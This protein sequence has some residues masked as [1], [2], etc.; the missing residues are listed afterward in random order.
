MYLTVTICTRNRAASLGRT[1]ASIER[2]KR[3]ACDWELLV[4]DNGSNDNTSE[5]LSAFQARLPI[6]TQTQPVPG[7]SRARNAAIAAAAGHYLISTDDDVL[8]DPNWL[9]AFTDS[10]REWPQ[11]DLF[12]GRIV[13][14]LEPPVTEWFSRIMP[15][16]GVVLAVR[17]FGDIAIPLSP[18]CDHLPYG[19]NVAVRTAV[20]RRF[21]FD[22]RRGHGTAYCGEETTSF[23]AM[24]AA[25]HPGRWVPQSSVNH[26]ISPKRQ[27]I[28]YI[29]W[30]Y[31]ALGRTLVWEG[32]EDHA[33]GR[34]YGAPRWLW[35]RTI[36]RE[37]A[38]RIA[39]LTS[40]PEIW[41]KKL[42]QASLD[43]GRLRHYLT[44]PALVD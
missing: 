29:R 31:E 30:W 14:V 42:I 36:E 5:V 22:V 39:R 9:V 21:P 41:V 26:L 27:S 13:P 3:V 33:G 19:A 40:T 18:E 1:L 35:R 15:A 43:R 2:A 10:F 17:D 8:V 24:L 4:T 20:Q 32:A 7:V 25:G 6:R 11:V 23:K 34:L 37:F 38:F 12:A 28:E 44:T 16:I